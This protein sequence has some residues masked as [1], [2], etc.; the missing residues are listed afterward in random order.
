MKQFLLGILCALALAGGAA[1]YVWYRA[2]E[3]LPHDWRRDNPR[4]RDYAP[5]V[6]RWRDADGVLQLTD[7]PP[8][9]RPYDTV[10]VDPDTNIVPDTLPRR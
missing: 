6:Y 4:S 8:T 1:A 3:W 7:T 10:R 9:D 2:P 5:A